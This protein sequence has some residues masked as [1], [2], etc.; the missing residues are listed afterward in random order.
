MHKILAVVRRE[1][2]ERVRQK[3]FWVMALVG[4][5]FFGA[6]I[7]LPS[8]MMRG[9]GVKNI[10]VVDGTTQGLGERVTAALD[11]ATTPPDTH[12]VFHAVRVP[13]GPGV[14]DSL[15]AQVDAKHLE[16]FLILTDALV[17]SGRAEYRASNVSS[18]TAIET[19]QRNLT[20]VVFSM[21]LEREGV[22]PTVVTK[23]RLPIALATQKISGGKSTQESAAQGFSLA[24]FMAIILYT[25]ILIY[26]INV[27]SSV[28]EEKTNRVVEVLVSSLRPFEL[29]LGKL[30]GVGAV[31]IFQFAIWA[32]SVRFLISKRS[33]GGGAPQ[34]GQVFEIPHVNS[35]TALVFAA[36]FL[37]GFFLYSAMFAAVGAV[38]ST[39]QEARQAQQPV[40][41]LL[42]VSFF[43]MFAMINDPNSTLAVTLSLIPFCSP[44]AMPVRW[45][46]GNLP[47]S[48]VALSLGILLVSIVL[49][50]WVASRIYRV[51]ILM[52]G[53]RPNIAELVRWVRTS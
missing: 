2:I 51:G 8:L 5:L 47:V 48:E 10:A 4:P 37:G 17:D 24:Y 44:I 29:M 6:I 43:A 23:A 45:A 18:F 40:S 22:N 25:S 38:S 35:A 26:G 11:R 12:R 1:F 46:T 41:V 30:I 52:T 34:A 7:L 33:G 21:R 14:V 31:S 32:V 13:A 19:I 3:W 39:E 28:L 49:V 27:M 53:K 16:G 42:M 36:Y 20:Q 50:T 9:G 15:R